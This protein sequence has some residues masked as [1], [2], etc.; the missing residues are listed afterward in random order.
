MQSDTLPFTAGTPGYRL[1][2]HLGE[3]NHCP[4][5]DRSHW[6]VGRMTAECA[7]CGTALPIGVGRTAGGGLFRSQGKPG[8]PLAA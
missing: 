4:G 3:D 7:Y 2:Y 6:L 8:V 1:A 5:C